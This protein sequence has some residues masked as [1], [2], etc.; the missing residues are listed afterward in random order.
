[1]KDVM[2]GKE[3]DWIARARA[4]NPLV[5]N[6]V[7]GSWTAGPTG[8]PL[9]KYS[10]RDGACS[11][12]SVRAKLRKSKKPSGMHVRRFV[13]AAGLISRRSAERMC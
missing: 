6:F 10:P 13:T 4:L 9:R 2:S 12:N 5:R 8:D 7:G 3:I 11:H 1:L